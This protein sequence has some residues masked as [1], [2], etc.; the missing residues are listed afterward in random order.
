MLR[1]LTCYHKFLVKRKL[2]SEV[3]AFN[4]SLNIEPA[5]PQGFPARRS[6]ASP[7]LI[8]SIASDLVPGLLGRQLG[9]RH[10]GQRG[11]YL[12]HVRRQDQRGGSL[13]LLP[14]RGSQLQK[15]HGSRS[16]ESEQAAQAF[17][18]LQMPLLHPTAGFESLMVVLDSPATSIP[19]HP[20]PGLG[21]AFYG[22]R[23][24]Q[25]PLQRLDSFRRI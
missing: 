19:V 6:I 13:R 1:G 2:R 25:D 11:N 15:S 22:H 9:H 8:A 12:H 24:Q 3:N 4:Q 23:T 17:I 16:Q 5:F 14:S 10:M 21:D 20:L 18:V 7:S